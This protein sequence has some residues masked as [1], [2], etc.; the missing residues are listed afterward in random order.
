MFFP[1]KHY[2]TTLNL[3]F[4]N[5]FHEIPLFVPL[6]P[7]LDHIKPLISPEVATSSPGRAPTR[8]DAAED[9]GGAPAAP[10][11]AEAAAVAA[12]A[13]NAVWPWVEI[14]GGFHN[15]GVAPNHL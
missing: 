13:F 12:A 2:Q 8:P 11:R 15:W 6:K 10:E 9:G 4:P 7:P 5:I 14:I 3:W 1:S